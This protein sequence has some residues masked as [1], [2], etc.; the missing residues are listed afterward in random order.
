[1]GPLLKGFLVFCFLPARKCSHPAILVPIGMMFMAAVCSL[2]H[3]VNSLLP[4]AVWNLLPALSR[5][6]RPP[7]H[8]LVSQIGIRPSSPA[9]EHLKGKQGNGGN[10]AA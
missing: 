9:A 7:S 8:P 1:M 5:C 10:D 4:R 2:L 6:V 3:A